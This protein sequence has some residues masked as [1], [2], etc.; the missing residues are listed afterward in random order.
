MKCDQAAGVG[1]GGSRNT[2]QRQNDTSVRFPLLL[3]QVLEDADT[4]RF[5]DI[6]SW[7][8]DGTSFK[9]HS[10]RN[11]ESHGIMAKYFKNQTR[12]KSFQKQLSIY[13]FQRTSKGTNKGSYHHPLFIRGRKDL[14]ATIFR[15][16]ITAGSPF[17]S[18][19]DVGK[20]KSDSILKASTKT[21]TEH[22]PSEL[23]PSWETGHH[24]N[25]LDATGSS[26]S[27]SSKHQHEVGGVTT[28][29]QSLFDHHYQDPTFMTI[30]QPSPFPPSMIAEN[31]TT[32][33]A[34]SS[35]SILWD[36]ASRRMMIENPKDLID[37][38]IFTFGSK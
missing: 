7:L 8:P 38:I 12:Y 2:E 16:K 26:S 18:T 15:P 25:F 33:A 32:A 6:I 30:P 9:I 35:S 27:E 19:L 13:Q 21:I 17:S 24:Q 11:F 3:Y 5:Q 37:E 28:N 14:C 1:G 36:N 31:T 29:F 10:P 22:P 34:A 20:K 23:N 4:Q